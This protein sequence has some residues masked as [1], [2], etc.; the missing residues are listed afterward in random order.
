MSKVTSQSYDLLLLDTSS[1]NRF[2]FPEIEAT[3]TMLVLNAGS[4]GKCYDQA[5]RWR[6]TDSVRKVLLT[7]AEAGEVFHSCTCGGY[8]QFCRNRDSNS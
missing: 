4:G 3:D 7:K 1:E 6:Q 5:R 2:L 8:G